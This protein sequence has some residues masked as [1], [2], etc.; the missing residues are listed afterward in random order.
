MHVIC[1][2]LYCQCFEFNYKV[3]NA[4]LALL[5]CFYLSFSICYLAF[6]TKHC[7]DFS[8]K[9]IPILEVFFIFYLI[10]F[11]LC[12]NVCNT[13]SKSDQDC[14]NPVVCY[15]NSVTLKEQLY[16]VSSV[17]KFHLVTIKPFWVQ[18]HTFRHNYLLC[19]VVYYQYWCC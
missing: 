17:L 8:D 16:S 1:F 15:Y 14:C 12:I 3:S 7:F 10:W 9:V 2:S 19:F 11:L 13:P 5:E 18:N 6:V 4:L